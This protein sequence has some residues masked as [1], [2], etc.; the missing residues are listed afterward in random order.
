V[1]F[2]NPLL[3][4]AVGAGAGALSGAM[5]DLGINDSFM[6]ELGATL[7]NGTAAV[8]VLVRKSTP[9][10][11]L[12]GLAPFAGKGK[13]L[14]TSLTADGEEALRKVLESSGAMPDAPGA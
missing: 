14:K 10:K 4:M 12:A 6:K 8:F 9:D 2:L 13:V 1:L 3:G 5:T 11:V 7:S